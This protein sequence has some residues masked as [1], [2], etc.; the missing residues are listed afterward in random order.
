MVT[1]WKRRFVKNENFNIYLKKLSGYATNNSRYVTL[2]FFDNII[3]F[4]N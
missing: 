2:M 1:I 3:R 4:I